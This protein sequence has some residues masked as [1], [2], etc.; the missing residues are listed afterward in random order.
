[1][2][3]FSQGRINIETLIIV[4]VLTLF[5]II[6][7]V[8]LSRKNKYDTSKFIVSQSY[9]ME[10][11]GIF[12][13][14]L[15]YIKD[16]NSLPQG[17]DNKSFYTYF[18]KYISRPGTEEIF[19]L[20]DSVLKVVPMD[21][22][23]ILEKY[24]DYFYR[25]DFNN[26]YAFLNVLN[27]HECLK[28]TLSEEQYN[29]YVN[30]RIKNLKKEEFA[31]FSDEEIRFYEKFAE[32]NISRTIV[33][34]LGDIFFEKND[35]D[36]ALKYYESSLS[37]KQEH[38]KLYKSTLRKVSHVY[39]IFESI[40]YSLYYIALLHIVDPSHKLAEEE[41]KRS[42]KHHHL[43]SYYGDIIEKVKLGREEFVLYI[44]DIFDKRNLDFN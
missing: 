40:S 31:S 43:S 32:E 44:K 5:I 4:I 42:L 11:T 6:T 28:E 12:N 19:A 14:V 41:L 23:N 3:N 1:M 20:L 10:D 34:K 37:L 35:L 7:I 24:L 38:D 30:S 29:N 17:V 26:F 13:I 21:D 36:K 39:G 2:R 33:I 25:S 27:S 18:L 8:V 9:Y 22:P 16:N 15:N